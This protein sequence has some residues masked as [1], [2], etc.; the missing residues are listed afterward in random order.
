M[1]RRRMTLVMM[2]LAMH[3][4]LI[5][6]AEATVL[7][8]LSEATVL[9]TITVAILSQIKIIITTAFLPLLPIIKMHQDIHMTTPVTTLQTSL[10]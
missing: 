9:T 2:T 1:A 10:N 3:L 6:M 7:I 8:T 4:L 5:T